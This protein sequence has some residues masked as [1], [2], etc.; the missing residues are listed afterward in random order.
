MNKTISILLLIALSIWSLL[1]FYKNLDNPNN[2]KFYAALAGLII[3]NI[4]LGL[5][6]RGL[7][8]K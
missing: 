8:K 4:L 1:I 6:V 7:Y 3:F 2:W 5:V